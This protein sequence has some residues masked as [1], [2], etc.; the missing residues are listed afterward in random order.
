VEPGSNISTAY[1]KSQE[2]KKREPI[3][4]EYKW[5]TLFLGDINNGN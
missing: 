4:R 1:L 3:T 5:A 2:T